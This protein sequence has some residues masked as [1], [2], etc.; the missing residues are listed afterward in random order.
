MCLL[1]VIL[2]MFSSQQTFAGWS[3]F[4]EIASSFIIHACSQNI[5]LNEFDAEIHKFLHAR[6]ID[7][8]VKVKN[9]SRLCRVFI[10]PKC[11]FNNILQPVSELDNHL[12][13]WSTNKD[14]LY[15][16]AKFYNSARKCTEKIDAYPKALEEFLFEMQDIISDL[17]GLLQAQESFQSVIIKND[18]TKKM[19]TYEEEAVLQDWIIV[20]RNQPSPKSKIVELQAFLRYLLIVKKKGT[21]TLDVLQEANFDSKKNFCN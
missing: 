8:S 7:L 12:N 21:K 17:D 16:Y 18:F 9:G 13:T 1:L 6:V 10:C 2:L 15:Y 5:S 19:A 11:F 20:G 3:Y 4:Y 14:L